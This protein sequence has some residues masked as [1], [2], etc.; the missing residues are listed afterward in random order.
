MK[1]EPP[2]KRDESPDCVL[3]PEAVEERVQESQT[4]QQEAKPDPVDQSAVI[5]EKP[6]EVE[7]SAVILEKPTS[8]SQEQFEEIRKSEVDQPIVKEEPVKLE[9][10]Q[11]QVEE[12][13]SQVQP[14]PVVPSQPEPVQEA[15]K[16][17]PR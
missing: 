4:A 8:A 7:T 6:Q 14:E 5:L 9:E 10:A 15:V 1:E 17:E 13:E 3:E 11:P 16:E 12:P 2:K